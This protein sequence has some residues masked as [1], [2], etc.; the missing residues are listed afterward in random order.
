VLSYIRQTGHTAL[1][2]EPT[3]ARSTNAVLSVGLSVTVSVY[4]IALCIEYRHRRTRNRNLPGYTC[5][6]RQSRCHG[7]L[8]I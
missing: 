4:A 6:Q 7:F 2:C 1:N 3:E 5:H 8:Y